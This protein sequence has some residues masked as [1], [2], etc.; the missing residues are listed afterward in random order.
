MHTTAIDE[1]LVSLTAPESFAAE[2]YLGLRLR[3]ERARSAH[4]VRAIAI[5]SPG[6]GDGKTITSINLAGALG[7][8][9]G[10]RVLLIDADLRSPSIQS[11]LGIPDHDRPGLS[12]AVA[13]SNVALEDV[14]QRPSF[15]PFALISAGQSSVA[16]HEL[17]RSDRLDLLLNQARSQFDYVLLDTPPL[18]PVFDAALMARAVDG[19]LV[20][21]AAHKTPRKQLEE[22]LDLLDPAKVLGIVFNNDTRPGFGRYNSYY[23]R[24]FGGRRQR[25]AI[26]VRQ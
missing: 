17:L 6:T 13:D 19:I 15:L 18:T 4:D 1:H 8:S 10:D 9:A 20:V 2:Q 23:R 14:V 21:V 24:Y 12:D 3:V 5:T 7:R 25:T 26:G 11:R 16:P 22:S